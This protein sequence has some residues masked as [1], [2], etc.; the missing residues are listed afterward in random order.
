[1]NNRIGTKTIGQGGE[2]EVGKR[3]VELRGLSDVGAKAK[4]GEGEW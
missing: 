1:M 2:I 4:R 3:L